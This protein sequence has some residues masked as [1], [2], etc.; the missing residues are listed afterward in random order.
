VVATG[1]FSVRATLLPRPART[2]VRTLQRQKLDLARALAQQLSPNTR[3]IIAEHSGH[4]IPLDQP[5][6]VVD[7][8]R[9][10]VEAAR[11]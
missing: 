9:Q 10:V 6:V 11:R 7:A 8:I 5:D 4:L 3:Y 2:L 1:G